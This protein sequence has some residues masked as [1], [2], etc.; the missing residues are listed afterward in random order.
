[1]AHYRMSDKSPSAIVTVGGNEKKIYQGEQIFLKNDDN[2]EIRFF[3]P[4]QEKIGVEIVFN[5]QT[6]N[7]GLLVLRPGEDIILDRFLGDKKKMK[8]DT[9]SIDGNNDAA[10]KA[11]EINGLIEFKFYKE[12]TWQTRGMTKGFNSLSST[13]TCGMG[14]VHTNFSSGLYSNEVDYSVTLD[15]MPSVV[16]SASAPV[17]T[18][19]IEQGGDSNQEIE[20]VNVDFE[21]LAFHTISYKMIP[22]SLKPTTEIT[23]IRNYCDQCSYRIR[24]QTWKYCPSC[25]NKLD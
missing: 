3:N 22:E 17:E 20:N 16:A 9:Y 7:E 12:K 1:M 25:G 8:F 11:A 18:G 24:K 6:K 15:E 5:N 13:N 14:S 2:F 19:R 10:V 21:T 4:L 23:E